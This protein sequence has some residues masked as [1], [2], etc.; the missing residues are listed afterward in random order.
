MGCLIKK[1]CYR[2]SLIFGSLHGTKVKMS[3]KPF[4]QGYC[5]KKLIKKEGTLEKVGWI[6][7][8]TSVL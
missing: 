6:K 4:N 1:L 8:R 5:L 2:T 3:Q 7:C